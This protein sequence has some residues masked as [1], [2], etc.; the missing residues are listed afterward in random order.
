M[1]GDDD[2]GTAITTSHIENV[3]NRRANYDLRPMLTGSEKFL[4]ALPVQMGRDFSTLLQAV[5]V[6]PLEPVVRSLVGQILH[7][8]RVCVL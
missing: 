7:K 8:N 6:L 2:D 4:H 5:P 1:H 3:F